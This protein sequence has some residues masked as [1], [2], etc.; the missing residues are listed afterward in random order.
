[1]LETKK[2]ESL[3]DP[4]ERWSLLGTILSI[5]GVVITVLGFAGL[6]GV[7]VSYYIVISLGFMALLVIMTVLVSRFKR[8]PTKVA[9]LKD[10]LINAFCGA[11]ESSS[12]NPKGRKEG[13]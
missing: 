10:S 11:L 6:K 3:L 12:L 1:M 7:P 2:K 13:V 9:T 5:A 4:A 8:S